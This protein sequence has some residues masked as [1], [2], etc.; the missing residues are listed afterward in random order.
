[1]IASYMVKD[2][3]AYLTIPS[4]GV[5]HT[6]LV[7]AFDVGKLFQFSTAWCIRR[8]GHAWYASAHIRR[9]DGQGTKVQMHR[10]LTNA[11]P[12]LVVD[13]RNGDGLDNRGNN[14]RNVTQH[15]NLFNRRGPVR[16]NATGILGVSWNKQRKKYR[17]QVQVYGEVRL[18]KYF[19]CPIEAGK[20]AA[21]ARAKVLEELGHPI[22]AAA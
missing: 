15:V 12:G 7:D 20:A 11:T 18:N 14:L 3:V 21:E 5:D 9:A 6:I 4:K 13:H 19:D 10:L 2:G 16:G 22:E 1:M 8:K 17:A